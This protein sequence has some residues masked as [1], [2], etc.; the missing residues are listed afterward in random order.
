MNLDM[1][2]TQA[3]H[4]SAAY[5]V[6]SLDDLSYLYKG[7]ARDLKERLKDHRAGRVSR[8][9]N[10]RPLQLVHHEYFDEYK[11]AHK[12][13]LFLKTGQGRAWLKRALSATD[14][15]APGGP[16]SGGKSVLL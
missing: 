12:R 5:V 11:D 9:K 15:S 3:E 2:I 8:T 7:C 1:A 10:R 13:E 4:R 14:C 16:A 6:S